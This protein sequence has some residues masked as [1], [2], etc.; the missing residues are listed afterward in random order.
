[1]TATTDE[2]PAVRNSPG[3]SR[4]SPVK[5]ILGLTRQ[6]SMLWPPRATSPSKYDK[7]NKVPPINVNMTPGSP[8]RSKNREVSFQIREVSVSL[9]TDLYV[10]SR[11][12]TATHTLHQCHREHCSAA[13]TRA[14]HLQLRDTAHGLE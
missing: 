2:V 8:S 11:A 3:P 9:L 4:Q 10:H 13:V 1:V 5:P 6:L 14:H 7:F 12:T